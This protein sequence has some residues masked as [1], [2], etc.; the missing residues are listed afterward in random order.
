MGAVRFGYGQGMNRNSLRDQ[1]GLYKQLIILFA[2]SNMPSTFMQRMTQ[3]L[4]P[5]T[6]CFA[7]LY[8]E[9]I[10]IYSISDE[11]HLDQL[12]QVLLVLRENKLYINLKKC[13]FLQDSLVFLDFV[14]N[15]DGI[16]KD[17]PM[18]RRSVSGVLQNLLL[19][20]RVS[21]I[22]LLFTGNLFRISVPLQ[23]QSPSV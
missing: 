10:L 15:V 14:V 4:Q 6:N 23:L 20:F 9:D 21:I 1:E 5:V 18:L 11:A 12:Q 13:S 17:G 7:V 19:R 8:F 3:V 16:K 22:W 2:F